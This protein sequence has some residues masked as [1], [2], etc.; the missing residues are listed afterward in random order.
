MA[1]RMKVV[2]APVPG[3]WPGTDTHY[4]VDNAEMKSTW[5]IA[6]QH[7][8]LFVFSGN[9]RLLRRSWLKNPCWTWSFQSS[10][11]FFDAAQSFGIV[12]EATDVLISWVATLHPS[13]FWPWTL[14]HWGLFWPR[15]S[16]LRFSRQKVNQWDVE[17]LSPYVL[18]AYCSV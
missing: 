14:R 6:P 12:I 13:P 4:E 5:F 9:V 10:P 3:H 16:V 15:P 1:N 17:L 2:L 18:E 11:T 8:S 7:S